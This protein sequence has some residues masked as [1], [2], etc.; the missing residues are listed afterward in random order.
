MIDVIPFAIFGSVESYFIVK[1]ITEAHQLIIHSSIKSD[2]GFV[3]KYIIVSPAAHRIHHSA[4]IAH[5]DKNFG[6]TFIFWDRL[7]KTYQPKTVVEKLGVSKNIY[8][9]DGVIK[10]IF[11]VIIRFF[12]YLKSDIKKLKINH[13][14]L[15]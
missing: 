8:N 13:K 6:Q 1:V 3:G 7:F 12:R 5:Y 15:K 4:K 2:W 11:K 10:D 9:K 14:Y